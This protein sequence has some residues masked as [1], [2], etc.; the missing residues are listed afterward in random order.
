MSSPE[1][2]PTLFLEAALAHSHPGS[3][4]LLPGSHLLGFVYLVTHGYDVELELL[5]RPMTNFWSTF[6][7]LGE[8]QTLVFCHYQERKEFNLS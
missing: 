1:P 8:N 7:A 2:L 3:N 5:S 6:P 4:F